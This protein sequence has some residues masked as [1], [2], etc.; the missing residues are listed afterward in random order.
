[1]IAVIDG[2]AVRARPVL[3]ALAGMSFEARSA[4]AGDVIDR[5][6]KL[7]IPSSFS[8][9]RMT[10]TLRDRGLIG[11]ILRMIESGRPVLGIGDGLTMLFDVSYEDQQH[12]GLGAVPGCAKSFDFGRHPAARHFSVPH[13]GWNRVHWA[14]SC[15]LL[16]GLESGAYFYFDHCVR[17]APL[18]RRAVA[19]TTNHGVDF[20]S[21]IWQG[22]LFGTVFYPERSEDAGMAV[23]RNFATL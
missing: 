18:D 9:R 14:M 16:D 21:V 2:D 12:T 4:T 19:A 7:I 23:L 8:Y 6:S 17:P 1:M 13:Q 10:A 5:A 11:S 22:D 20:P 3:A 15:P